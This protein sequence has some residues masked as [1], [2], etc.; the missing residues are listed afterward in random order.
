MQESVTTASNNDFRLALRFNI[1][2]EEL[3]HFCNNII[4]L[5]DDE[6]LKGQSTGMIAVNI[7][8][9][10]KYAIDLK[11]E[12][13]PIMGTE[14]PVIHEGKD[15]GFN[16]FKAN[17]VRGMFITF[18]E[19]PRGFPGFFDIVSGIA[20][21]GLGIGKIKFSGVEKSISLEEVKKH[22]P[23][24]ETLHPA[25]ILF[26]KNMF[27]PANLATYPNIR[28]ATYTILTGCA[29]LPFY[30]ASEK[31]KNSDDI[32]ITEKY[33][34]A[35]L[36]AARSKFNGSSECMQKFFSQNLF[37]VLFEELFTYESTVFSIFQ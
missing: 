34:E 12:E 33:I 31:L 3:Q 22:Y 4:R 17:I 27:T 11:F 23:D 1:T 37:K 16:S 9:A 10:L 2:S 21:A 28:L 6:A 8:R 35:A 13:K 36:Q 29:L 5:I 25:Q 32:I 24:N 20:S 7:T 26:L 14:H 30:Y 18:V 15:P 19:H